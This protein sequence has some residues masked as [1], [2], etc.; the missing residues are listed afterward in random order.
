M[1]SVH[2]IWNALLPGRVERDIDRELAF[3][4][5]E[6]ASE[7]RAEG[8]SDDEALRRARTQLGNVIV[9]RERTRDADVARG[10][11]TLLRNVRYAAG[12]SSAGQASPSQSSLTLALGIGANS[13][14]FSAIRRRTSAAA[15][16]S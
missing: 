7:L 14:V 15:P 9:Q 4:I 10:M 3:H 5:A 2:R 1:R 13:A 16:V 11:D 6:R 8:L 12:H